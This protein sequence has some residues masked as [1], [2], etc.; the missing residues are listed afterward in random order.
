MKITNLDREN[1]ELVADRARRVLTA[2]GEELGLE[3]KYGGGSYDALKFSIRGDF[4]LKE[5]A[6]GKSGEQAEFERFCALYDFKPED[7]GK[8]VDIGGETYRL[9]GF[10]PRRR[11]NQIVLERAYDKKRFVFPL[12]AVRA[13]FPA[14]PD[15]RSA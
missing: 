9:V 13:P 14:I 3:F 15:G 10:E 12:R 1:V 7:F 11:K 6:E 4:I 2:L 8:R 5:T